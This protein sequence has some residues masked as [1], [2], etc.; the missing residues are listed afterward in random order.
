MAIRCPDDTSQLLARVAE[1]DSSAADQLLHRHRERLVAMVRLRM[2]GR[3]TARFDP[4]DVV[5][6]SLVEAHH[7]LPKYAKSQP[8]PFYL[9]L[10]GI[11]WQRLVHLQ[12]QHLYAK[13]RSVGREERVPFVS[14]QSEALLAERLVQSATR[15]SGH[16][17]RKEVRTRVRAAIQKLPDISREIIVLR[18]LEELSF[19]EITEVLGLSEAA[20]YSRYRRAIES[21]TQSLA[22]HSD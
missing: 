3:L 7:K 14:D 2:D 1:G 21:L 16:V 19:K 11:A 22:E 12:R 8:I 10:R 6:D 4:S 20:I 9:W 15:G 17:I 5:Q 13:R 18:H